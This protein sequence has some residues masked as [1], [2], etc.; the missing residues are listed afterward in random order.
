M[1]AL[2]NKR[3][4]VRDSE[5]LTN[6]DLLKTSWKYQAKEFFNNSN[7]HGVHYIAEKDRPFHEKLVPTYLNRRGKDE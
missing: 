2:Q 6:V 4:S 5:N 7:L 1:D 3:K